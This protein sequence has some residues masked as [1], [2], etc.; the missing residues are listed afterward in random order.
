MAEPE[1]QSH[2]DLSKLSYLHLPQ[3][4]SIYPLLD[5]TKFALLMCSL[6]LSQ[7]SAGKLHAGFRVPL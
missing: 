5:F 6:A 3:S 2:P 7:D 1:I 4:H